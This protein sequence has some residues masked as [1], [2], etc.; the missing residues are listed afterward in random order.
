MITLRGPEPEEFAMMAEK[1]REFHAASEYQRIPYCVESMIETFWS[2]YEKDMLIVAV[3]GDRVVGGVGG[4]YAK[5]F[6]NKA[7]QIGCERFW[8]L[9]PENR[10]SMAGLL[11]LNG[12][13]AAA[14]RA[15]CTE[16]M[17]LSL[18]DGGIA[19]KIYRRRG[20]KL[21]EHAYIKSL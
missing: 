18:D 13:E 17:M 16:W 7:V 12:I 3:E 21:V 5:L 6:F 9:E 1:G 14:K 10:S 15:G 19:D 11:L 20:Y 8:W 2:M 4:L